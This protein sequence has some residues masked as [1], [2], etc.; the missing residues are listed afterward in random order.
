MRW[1]TPR[2]VTV[3]WNFFSQNRFFLKDGLPYLDRT[4]GHLDPIKR[5][6]IEVKFLWKGNFCNRKWIRKSKF[7]EK[8]IFITEKWKES[9][10]SLKKKFLQQK[11]WKGS[12]IYHLELTQCCFGQRQTSSRRWWK[13]IAK[14]ARVVMGQD[15]LL[16]SGR[17]AW[18]NPIR[19]GFSEVEYRIENCEEG[20]I[21]IIR[22]WN[23]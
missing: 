20:I 23:Y 7:S 18:W 9:Q 4:K 19:K 6:E 15:L 3:L 21:P 13:K 17:F 8:V 5:K 16:K 10:L 22:L 12:Q 11:I 2:G 14:K 1:N